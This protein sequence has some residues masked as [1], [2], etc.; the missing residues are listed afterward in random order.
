MSWV[1]IDKDKALSPGDIIELDFKIL[2]GLWLSSI[3]IAT[4]EW[5]LANRTDW[6]IISNSLPA[7]G[8]ITFT[9]QIKDQAQG[10]WLQSPAGPAGLV[11]TVIAVTA[12]TIAASICAVGLITSLVLYEARMFVKETTATPGGQIAS[13]GVGAV[14]IAALIFVFYKYVLGK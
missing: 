5:N 13:T 1:K 2:S 12:A 3:E 14:G 11:F 6:E 9:I 10:S 7:Q 4:I 8:M